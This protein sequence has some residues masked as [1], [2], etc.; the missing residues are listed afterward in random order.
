[1]SCPWSYAVS[2]H[3]GQ[4]FGLA[5]LAMHSLPG[6]AS[7]WGGPTCGSWTR[8]RTARTAT[9]RATSRSPPSSRSATRRFIQ[10]LCNFCYGVMILLG[11]F[12]DRK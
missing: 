10:P 1:S 11:F 5:V 6:L 8:A 12:K 2:G 9:P 7:T 3:W 4:F